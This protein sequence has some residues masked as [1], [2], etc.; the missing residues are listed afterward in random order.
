MDYLKVQNVTLN[1]TLGGET[2]I[3]KNM[4]AK[5][6]DY[7][8]FYE[9][10][11]EITGIYLFP[12]ISTFGII[13][14][15]FIIIVYAKSKIYSTSFYLIALSTSD[16]LKLLNDLAYFLVT[17]IRKWDANLGHQIFILLYS[18]THYIFFLTALNTS[19]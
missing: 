1:M 15:I 3:K 13:G 16:I 14:N 19:W 2:T 11:R 7:Q 4:E 10:M 5:Y 18:Y 12:F 9:V 8:Q 17:V 6:E